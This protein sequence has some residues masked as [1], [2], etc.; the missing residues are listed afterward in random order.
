[1]GIDRAEF[2]RTRA[3]LHGALMSLVRTRRYEDIAVEEILATANVGR[4]TFYTHYKSKDDLLEHGLEQLRALLSSASGSG[5]DQCRALFRHVSEYRDVRLALAGGRGEVIIVSALGGVLD[6]TLRRSL[7]ATGPNSLPRELLIE[8][9][10]ATIHTVLRWWLREGNAGVT[11][12]EADRI[13]RTLLLSGAPPEWKDA[14]REN[15]MAVD[16]DGNSGSAKLA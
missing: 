1:M 15:F 6:K 11:P 12:D 14:L 5:M 3:A 10:V 7:R 13:F 4:S 2:A 16:A 8:H 9:T